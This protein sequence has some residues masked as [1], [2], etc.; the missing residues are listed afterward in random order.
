LRLLAVQGAIP[1]SKAGQCVAAI[2]AELYG[3][4]A[5]WKGFRTP[6]LV[7]LI[8]GAAAEGA[9]QRFLGAT[10]DLRQAAAAHAV[11]LPHTACS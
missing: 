4:G 8:R 10:T 2:A 9:H 6:A 1:L 5:H 11:S 3:P 7:R